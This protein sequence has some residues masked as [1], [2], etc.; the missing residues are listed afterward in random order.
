MIFISHRG[1]CQEIPENSLLGFQKSLDLN[2]NFI[3][4]DVQLTQDQKLVVFHDPSLSRIYGVDS[5]VNEMKYGDLIKFSTKFGHQHISMLS[6]II[7][8]MQTH[9]NSITKLMIELKGENSAQPTCEII[10]SYGFQENCVFSG[11]HL[12]E[13]THAHELLPEIPICLNI[14]KCKEFNLNDLLKSGTPDT[15]PIPFAMFSLKSDFITNPEFIRQCHN[16]GVKA[17]SWNFKDK[18]RPFQLQKELF[19]WGLDGILFDNP[20]NVAHLRDFINQTTST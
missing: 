5:L 1:F 3:E 10:Q 13:L 15:F 20:Q 14:T 6:E 17:L 18:V 9:P 4:L 8:F 12:T 7:D 16:L 11:R 2:M 19:S